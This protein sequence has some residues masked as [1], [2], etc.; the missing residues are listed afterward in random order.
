MEAQLPFLSP[1]SN[2]DYNAHRTGQSQFEHKLA[3]LKALQRSEFQVSA[4]SPAEVADM[5]TKAG[6]PPVTMVAAQW[7]ASQ[8]AATGSYD[9]PGEAPVFSN[10]WL[11]ELADSKADANPSVDADQEVQVTI[12]LG[13]AVDN[14]PHDIILENVSLKRVLQVTRMIGEPHGF[15][16]EPYILKDRGGKGAGASS[17]DP[18]RRGTH[19]P[20]SRPIDLRCVDCNLPT[21]AHRLLIDQDDPSFSWQGRYIMRCVDCCM[22]GPPEVREAQLPWQPRFKSVKDFKRAADHAW[23]SKK[24]GDTENLSK[25]VRITSWQHAVDDIGL[26]YAGESRKSWRARIIQST[27]ETVAA[28][29][30]A[31]L[32]SSDEKRIQYLAALERWK[33]TYEDIAVSNGPPRMPLTDESEMKEAVFDDCFIPDSVAQWLNEI[34]Q[35]VD[36]YFMCRRIGCLFVGLNCMWSFV[37]GYCRY[38]CPLCGQKYVPWQDRAMS[39]KAQ[40][41][42]VLENIHGLALTDQGILLPGG[43]TEAGASIETVSTPV[44]RQPRV[45]MYMCEWSNTTDQALLNDFMAITIGLKQQIRASNDSQLIKEIQRL[46]SHSKRSYFSDMQMPAEAKRVIDEFNEQKSTPVHERFTYEHLLPGFQGMQYPYVEGEAI[47]SHTDIMRM[48]G[49]A[50]YMVTKAMHMA[51]L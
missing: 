24:R 10:P 49:L 38:R 20:G 29:T 44:G 31:I 47:L 34:V 15:K 48:I 3:Y 42:L 17:E 27:I 6:L 23:E 46:S 19:R 8:L 14:T 4:Y 12:N 16:I 18:N 2:L 51:R 36:Q 25:R 39:V 45:T 37:V 26:R 21:V 35:G 32:K 28:I 50:R 7:E 11:Q 30:A 13:T 33:R 40:K 5:R 22:M 43:A 1:D 41:C 9:G